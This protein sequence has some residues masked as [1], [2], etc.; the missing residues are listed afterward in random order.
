MKPRS[1]RD[2]R[3]L[4][5][6]GVEALTVSLFNAYVDGKH[7]RRIAEIAREVMPS[8]P[9][10]ISSDVIPEMYEYER[11]ETTVVNSYIRPVVSKYVQ[12]LERELAARM[13]GRQAAYPAL[14]RRAFLGARGHG[15]AGQSADVGSR[16]RRRRA[17]SGSPRARVSTSC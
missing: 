2:L 11:A 17:R 7:E 16:R 3:G 8:I 12:N 6:K 14:R 10:S 1:R 15:Q 4:S 13:R 9:V 5:E